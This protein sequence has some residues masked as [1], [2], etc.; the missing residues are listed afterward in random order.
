MLPDARGGDA[1][2]RT[3]AARLAQRGAPRVIAAPRRASVA[4]LLRRRG[5]EQGEELELLYI[6]RP[7]SPRDPWSGQVAFPGGKQEPGDG[8]SDLRTALREVKEE[9]GLDLLGDGGGRS[10][11]GGGGGGDCGDG[12]GS[13]G[14]ASS[15]LDAVVAELDAGAGGS[16]AAPFALLGRLHDAPI[17]SG[18][19]QRE[20]AAYCCFV[21]LQRAAATPPLALQAG[22]VAAVRWVPLSHFAKAGAAQPF[23]L[24]RDGYG[25][26]PTSAAWP[27][28][29]RSALGVERAYFPSVVLPL[30]PAAPPPA[31]PPAP[32]RMQLWGMSLRATSELLELAGVAGARALCRPPA[33]FDNALANTLLEA[34]AAVEEAAVV[35]ARGRPL[36]EA[37]AGARAALAL[38]VAGAAGAAAAAALAVAR[39]ARGVGAR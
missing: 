22:E 5:D 2:L 37:S 13:V 18:G 29:L 16:A 20:G 23:A 28:W 7:Q 6:L 10:F 33:R 15:A 32:P 21:F 24:A 26:V 35:A 31:P 39:R 9:L 14:D 30:P 4:L 34:A 8:G 27:A 11:V 25:L 3:L 12:G 17:F 38:A 19:R 1:M 36:R